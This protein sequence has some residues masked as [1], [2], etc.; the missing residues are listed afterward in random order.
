MIAT[1]L[2]F[3]LAVLPQEPEV[4][5]PVV[6]SVGHV[7]E[8][9]G[10]LDEQGRFVAHE[11]ELKPAASDDVLLGTV[12]A[13]QTDPRAFTLLGQR[14]ETDG[15]TK[16]DNLDP[17]SLAGKRVKVEGSW[18]GPRKFRAESIAPRG[19]G[20]DRIAARLDELRK[21][22]GGWEAGLMIF[23]VWIADGTEVKHQRPLTEYGLATARK[24]GQP[25][26]DQ[27]QISRDEDDS[28]GKGIALTETLRLLGQI[29]LL[30]EFEDNYDLNNTPTPN[31]A[32]EE[33]RL[34]NQMSLRAR[35]AWAPS[36]DLAGVAELRYTQLYRRDD[37][38]G[39]NDS[40]V[41]HDGNLGETW[42]QWRDAL[43]NQGF[44][45]TV[46]RQDFDDPREW[47]YDQNLDALRFS[48]IRPDVR[49]DVSAS[50]TLTGGSERDQQ[51]WNAVA[52]LSNND[53]EAN[54]AAWT[55][56]RETDEVGVWVPDPVDPTNDVLVDLAENSL[57]MGVRALGDWLPQNQTWAEFAFLTGDRDA[58]VPQS[59]NVVVEN[60]DVSAWAYDV[61]TTWSPPYAA[62]LYF[63]IGYA[64]G[65]GDSSVGESYRQTGYQDNNGRFGGVTSFSYYGELFEPELSNLGISTLGVGARIAE[66]TSLDLVFHTYTQDEPANLFSPRPGIEAN[67]DQQPNGLNADL[68]WE[69]DAIFGYRRFKS[70]DV[71]IVGAMF[72][73][74]DGFT[75]DDTAYF[76]KVQV[77]YR[78]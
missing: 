12:P 67:L 38:N 9:R 20:R 16:W 39:V 30:S 53:E 6:L 27:E 3:S 46:G 1:L 63:T 64:L 19:E 17:G 65:T 21:V 57:H 44:D 35:I 78:F 10:S 55:M 75:I 33:D 71:E 68:G 40:E 36:A 14:V 22:E 50:T 26:Q 54:L 52:Y 49:F 76:A 72:E 5:T 69:L 51:S 31:D 58:P 28:F 56:L 34:D 60:F 15:E 23:S 41:E 66:R 61:G 62:P 7:I 25:D 43:G 29:E 11:I 13:D 59:S 45:I 4:S 47:L 24:I 74:G 2:S 77:R 18:K 48:W 70:L 73:P 32:F 37:D 8:V 42:L